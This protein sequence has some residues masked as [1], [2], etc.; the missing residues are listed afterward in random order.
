MKPFVGLEVLRV[1]ADRRERGA[2]GLVERGLRLEHRFG[3]G[4]QAVELRLER[5]DA[6][7]RPADASGNRAELRGVVGRPVVEIFCSCRG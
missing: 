4:R 7:R 3:G 1:Q 2:F 5:G 6:G